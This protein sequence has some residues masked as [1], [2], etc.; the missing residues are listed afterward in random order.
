[1]DIYVDGVML[2]TWTSSGTTSGFET[3]DLGVAGK[4]VELRGVQADSEWLSI[5]EVCTQYTTSVGGIGVQTFNANAR[6]MKDLTTFQ[7]KHG[8]LT[9]R[10]EK[11]NALQ[12][13]FG[14]FC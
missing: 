3:V 11:S 9:V 1:M 5:L 6:R 2:T 13:C 10:R 4:T 14:I 12:V 8:A 7:T